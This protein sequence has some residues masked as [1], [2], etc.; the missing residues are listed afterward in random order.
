MYKRQLLASAGIL[1]L[2]LSFGAQ[3]LIQDVLAG[4]FIIFEE[5]FCLLYTSS[6]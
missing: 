1:G 5:Q 6:W 2:A 3:S 4:L